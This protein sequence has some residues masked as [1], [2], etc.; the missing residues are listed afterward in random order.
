MTDAII[1]YCGLACESCPIRLATLEKD[2]SVKARLRIE[3]AEELARIYKTVPKPWIIS[4]CDGCKATGG[5]LFT[6]C[7]DCEIRKCAIVKQV[8]NCAYCGEYACDKLKRHFA[9][10]PD[11]QARL[12]EIRKNN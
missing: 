7:T 4:D 3:I 2:D 6:G 11:A 9:I 1:A 8:I 12:E 10:D 5:R